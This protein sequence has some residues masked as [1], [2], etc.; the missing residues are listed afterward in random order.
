MK[1]ENKV[2]WVSF[3]VFS[4]SVFDLKAAVYVCCHGE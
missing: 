3:F 4:I 2:S 1:E